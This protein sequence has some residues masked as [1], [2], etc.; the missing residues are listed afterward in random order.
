MFFWLGESAFGNDT[1][2]QVHNGP[3]SSDAKP[4][5]CQSDTVSRK[6]I[7]ARWAIITGHINFLGICEVESALGVDRKQVCV[8]A[9]EA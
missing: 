5:I 1:A 4:D 9:G 2:F 8:V 6:G 7:Q 3:I